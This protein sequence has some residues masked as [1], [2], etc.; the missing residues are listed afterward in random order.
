MPVVSIRFRRSKAEEPQENGLKSLRFVFHCLLLA[1]S[2]LTETE[3]FAFRQKFLVLQQ[4]EGGAAWETVDAGLPA[5]TR[6]KTVRVKRYAM[7]TAF[8][9]IVEEDPIFYVTGIFGSLKVDLRVEPEQARVENPGN[10]PVLPS[11]YFVTGTVGD[12][13]FW[14]AVTDRSSSSHYVCAGSR[15]ERFKESPEGVDFELEM[16]SDITD[17]SGK[18]FYLFKSLAGERAEMRLEEESENS[19]SI[20]GT[21]SEIHKA[22]IISLNCV[23]LK[24]R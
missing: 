15:Q 18:R 1:F 5:H 14:C 16:L 9:L 22:L 7:A 24:Y 20:S 17:A 4:N 13:E 10:M 8:G 3:C 11:D 23:L 21:G 12:E 6:L 19:F 2:C